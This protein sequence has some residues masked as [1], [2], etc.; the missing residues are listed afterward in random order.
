[1]AQKACRS[2][3]KHTAHFWRLQS[4]KWQVVSRAHPHTVS[5]GCTHLQLSL[6]I[7]C[8]L[9]PVTLRRALRQRF[10]TDMLTLVSGMEEDVLGSCQ[11][12]ENMQKLMV[13]TDKEGSEGTHTH[14]THTHTYTHTHTHSVRYVHGKSTNPTTHLPILVCI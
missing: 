12:A 8:V 3:E 13:M 4:D 14:H 10:S 9:L 1:M 6:H 7:V 11:A 5:G 2:T